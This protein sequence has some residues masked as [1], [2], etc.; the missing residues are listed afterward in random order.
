MKLG[1]AVAAVETQD[2]MTNPQIIAKVRTYFGEGAP[3]VQPP[4][5]G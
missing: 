4:G 1:G 2:K 5:R 3:R